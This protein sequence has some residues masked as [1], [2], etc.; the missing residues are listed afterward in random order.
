MMG[1]LSAPQVSAEV[2]QWIKA[3]SSTVITSLLISG[4]LSPV[5]GGGHL[6][7][8]TCSAVPVVRRGAAAASNFMKS[9]KLNGRHSSQWSVRLSPI[10]DEIVTQPSCR[11]MADV[12]DAEKPF[13]VGAGGLCLS[14]ITSNPSGPLS[15]R[16]AY[17]NL[18]SA[19][20]LT[21]DS[22]QVQEEALS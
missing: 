16:R 21:D 8:V 7:D 11:A 14:L 4:M 17:S 5:L 12:Q 2:V 10:P 20:Q 6:G 1:I 15:R 18:R 9:N 3:S 22:S 13:T 19:F